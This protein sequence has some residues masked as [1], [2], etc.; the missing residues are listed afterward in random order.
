MC[1]KI[2]Y[3]CQGSFGVQVKSGTVVAACFGQ[4]STAAIRAPPQRA[5]TFVFQLPTAVLCFAAAVSM[6]PVYPIKGPPYG[7]TNASEN[8]DLVRIIHA[9][10][11]DN[12]VAVIPLATTISIQVTV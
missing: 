6:A 3:S 4:I 9:G 1:D 5:Q 7:Q 10:L 2:V 12:H 11:H 8:K